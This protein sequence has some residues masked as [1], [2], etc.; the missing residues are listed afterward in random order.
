MEGDRGRREKWKGKE[1]GGGM[2]EEKGEEE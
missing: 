1:G 2:E